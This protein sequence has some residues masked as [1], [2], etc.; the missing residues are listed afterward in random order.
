MRIFNISFAYPPFVE[1]GGPPKKVQ[2]ISRG[3]AERHFVTVL[4]ANYGQE[5]TTIDGWDEGVRVV[6]TRTLFRYHNAITV[7][8]D[9]RVISRRLAIASDVA[10]IYGIYDL[11]GTTAGRACRSAGVPYIVETLG[12]FRPK[13]RSVVKKRLYHALLGR[14]L[15]GGASRLIVTSGLERDELLQADLPVEKI[16][17]RRNGV[18]LGDFASLPPPGAFR[19]SLGLG[20]DDFVAIFLGR[21]TA[22]K[23][24]ELLL[25][26]LMEP[27]AERMRA[28]FVGPDEDGTRC[29]L[30]ARASRLGLRDR[31]FFV[32]P[33]Y[34]RDKLQALV[35]ANVFVL[36]SGNESFGTATV[37]AMAC[38]VPVV[39]SDRCG[40]ARE[41][42]GRAGLVCRPNAE[43]LL[44]ALLRLASDPAL[45]FRLGDMGRKLAQQFSWDEAV[46]Q[47]EALYEEVIAESADRAA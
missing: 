29:R 27:G 33:L 42:E 21:L 19:Q 17:L 45:R 46:A 2:A 36:P 26:A 30:E 8:P 39:V 47:M 44:V 3:L 9:A 12:M 24:P 6:Y 28:V 31:T 18:D 4:T 13:V 40:I 38:G 10:H 20:A 22:L 37:E 7:N 25:E 14:Q 16:V 34:E 35:D 43:S 11:L 41:I 32:G 15:I 5:R 1:M 23:R